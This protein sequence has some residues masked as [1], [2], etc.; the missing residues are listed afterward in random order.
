MD[1]SECYQRKGIADVFLVLLLLLMSVVDAFWV[2]SAPTSRR[3]NDEQLLLPSSP[4]PSTGHRRTTRLMSSFGSSS[5]KMK[6]ILPLLSLASNHFISQALHAFVKLGISDIL[7]SAQNSGDGE[8]FMT[9]ENIAKSLGPNTNQDALLRTLRLLTTVDILE[10]KMI[11]TTW[12]NDEGQHENSNNSNTIYQNVAFRLTELGSM[13]QSTDTVDGTKSLASCVLHW[14]E[15]PLWNVGFGVPAFIKGGDTS[16]LSTENTKIPDDNNNTKMVN[17]SDMDPFTIVNGQSS[18]YFYNKDEHPQSL[19]YANDFVRFIADNEIDEIVDAIDWS[20]I[21]SYANDNDMKTASRVDNGR[22]TVDKVA[23]LDIG[24]Y[25]GKVLDAIA[26]QYPSIECKCLDL[27]HVIEQIKENNRKKPSSSTRSTIK[28]SPVELIGGDIFAD[29]STLPND[30][31]VILMK[32]FLDRCMWNDK[33]TLQILHTCYKLLPPANEKNC[34]VLAE[35]VI[36]DPGSFQDSNGDK[37]NDPVFQMQRKMQLTL[38]AIYMY[39]GRERQ[40]TRSEWV[41]LANEANFVLDEIIHTGLP[42]C[43]LLVLHKE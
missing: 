4:R 28:E 27:P 32:H 36:P 30:C 12:D 15:E 3:I 39:V 11:G 1:G 34:L 29:L 33:E 13:L 22:N 21:L 14:M 37:I 38:D 8:S 31:N 42:T 40:R 17:S 35:A 19:K 16:V 18:D 24:G 23:L 43:S 26:T 41:A 10:D 25:N 20:S 6:P 2:A 7:T 5:S 9:L